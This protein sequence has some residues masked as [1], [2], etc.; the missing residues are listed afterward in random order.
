MAVKCPKC[1]T[2]NPADSKFCK[3][4][5][6]PI[7]SIDKI[8]LHTETLEVPKTELTTGSTFADRYQIIEELGKGGMGRVYKVMDKEV[9]A[10]VALKL[11][12]PEIAADENTIE[13][14]RNELKTARDVS[15]KNVCRMYDLNR[16]EGSYYI[17]MEYVTGED[18]KS[19]IR[20]SK[21]LAIGTA[22]S[23]AKQVC[24]GLAEA[25]RLGIIHR[26]LKPSNIM[27]D[28]DGNVR[29]MD[30]GIARSLREKSITGAGV[31]IGTPEY[32]SP[33]QVEGKEV[34]QR[35]DIY[36]LGVILY[37][38]VTGR[39]PFEGDTG[40]S[41]AVKH[42]TE[43]PK[44][45]R[46][47]NAQISD[48]LSRLILKCLEKDK[49]KRYQS[50]G[51]VRSEL[52]NIEEGMPTTQQVIPEKK[53]LTSREIT[54]QFNLKK[55]I[56]P[57]LIFIGIIIVG[58]TVWQLLPKKVAIP[59][60]SDKPSVAVM[61]F[62]N[63]TGDEGLDHWSA[64]LTDLLIKDLTQSKYIRV[65][66]EDKLVNILEEHNHQESKSYSTNVLKEVAAQGRV[67]HILQ[68]NY[69]KAGNVYR[70]NVTLQE[71]ATMEII[72]S[73]GVEGTGE[74][75]VFTMVDEL[76]RKIKARFKLTA[77][78]IASDIDKDVGKITTSSPE[79]YQFYREAIKLSERGENQ[80]AIPFFE[81]AISIDPAF[82]IAYLHMAISF[83]NLG[84]FNEEKK[85]LEKAFS[86]RD[87]VTDR[88]RY[89]SEAELNSTS[90]K[91]YDL[92]PASIHPQQKA[93]IRQG[94]NCSHPTRGET[95]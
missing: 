13:R 15:H 20:R 66:P 43:E 29:I 8:P 28:R 32:M 92:Q 5:A 21:Q 76:T 48:D 73:E 57:T 78:D 80:K 58:L 50:A 37:E 35:S 87:R 19:F 25:H 69:A 41:V 7:T 40:L 27:I 89:L 39:V 26:D 51:D 46:E 68:G 94:S 79:A 62:K 49:A 63:N 16:E 85:N 53:P 95:R 65:L 33:E 6:E 45:P 31:M 52:T 30:F 56:I 12:K 81:K 70:V 61:Y 18:L 1:Q 67:N 47:F 86:L 24:E 44:D 60:P 71:A 75:S 91:T 36:S 42:K 77:E 59:V 90:E 54:V 82:A 3:E 11:I 38:L 9:N 93:G 23:I 10:K 83:Y 74:D 34:D 84:L 4:C 55:L 64:M 2:E 88:E 22:V 14:F 72:G 17:T